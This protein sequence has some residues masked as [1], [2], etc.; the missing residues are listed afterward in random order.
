MAHA[1]REAL[2]SLALLLCP[3][4][5]HLASEAWARLGHEGDVVRQRWPVCREEFLARAT[6]TVV[7]QVNGKLRGRVQLAPDAGEEEVLAAAT[8]EPAVAAHLEGKTVR[9]T[10]HVPGKLINLVVT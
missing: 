8:A 7:V 9:R 2:E 5:P 6:V 1:V 10:V 3:F 4:A